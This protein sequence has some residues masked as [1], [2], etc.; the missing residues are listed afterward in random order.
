MWAL[1]NY[2]VKQRA[3]DCEPLRAELARLAERV[4]R[5]IG[6]GAVRIG[7]REAA[8]DLAVKAS[9]LKDRVSGRG[10]DRV[11]E[12]FK[13]LPKASATVGRDEEMI[14]TYIKNQE[15][16]DKQLDQLQ[17]KLAPS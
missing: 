12:F 9:R 14:R 16:A 5:E 4:E 3:L 11:V 8:G 6:R 2:G 13:A 10:L 17:L 1:R 7:M 15:M